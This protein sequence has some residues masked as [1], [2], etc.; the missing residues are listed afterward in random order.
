M[1]GDDDRKEPYTPNSAQR[2]GG[3]Q[4]T[5]KAGPGRS[6][7]TVTRAPQPT[8]LKSALRLDA[9]GQRRARFRKRTGFLIAAAVPLLFAAVA[10]LV[11]GD[12]IGMG[13]DLGLFALFTFATFLIRQGGEAED[14]YL[15]RTYASPPSVPRKL[16]GSLVLGGATMLTGLFG[17]EIGIVQSIG[18]GALAAGASVLTFGMDPMRAKGEISLSGVT[19]QMVEEAI[20]EANE[21]IDGIERAAADITDRTL[22]DRLTRITSRS[23]DILHRIEKDPSD[24]RRARKFLKV[25]LDGALEATRKYAR[26]QHDLGDSDMYLKFRSLL[27]DM[28][29]TFDDQYEKLLTN[30]RIDLDVEIDVLAERLNR[31]T[32][33]Q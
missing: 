26:T 1:A 12:A 11:S 23:R 29:S 13:V 30:D 24:L 32:V 17:W 22:R 6:D 28:Q 16:L 19:P 27:D 21:R 10:S 20:S 5:P 3:S 25:Y 7:P 18:L 33:L 14:A 15:D 31:E 4:A 2:F 8:R 9:S